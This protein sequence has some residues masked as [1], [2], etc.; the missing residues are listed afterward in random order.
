MALTPLVRQDVHA[1]AS[2]PPAAQKKAADQFSKVAQQA[3]RAGEAANT[4]GSDGQKTAVKHNQSK[5]QGRSERD[6]DQDGQHHQGKQTRLV[7]GMRVTTT[8]GHVTGRVTLGTREAKGSVNTAATANTAEPVRNTGQTL[9]AAGSMVLATPR[10]LETRNSRLGETGKASTDGTT[11]ATSPLNPETAIRGQQNSGGSSGGGGQQGQEG[12]T[13]DG[14][15][16]EGGGVVGN[17]NTGGIGGGGGSNIRPTATGA[18]PDEPD[19]DGTTRRQRIERWQ[20]VVQRFNLNGV[21]NDAIDA[22]LADVEFA[23]MGSYDFNAQSGMFRLWLKT[24]PSLLIFGQGQGSSFS[25]D[26]ISELI[27]SLL[28]SK[29]NLPDRESI[30]C[31]SASFIM[32]FPYKRAIDNPDK[33]TD[34]FRET[35]ALA[36][37]HNIVSSLLGEFSHLQWNQDFV[38]L[39]LDLLMSPEFDAVMTYFVS[40]SDDPLWKAGMAVMMLTENARVLSVERWQGI[41]AP[42]VLGGEQNDA[43]N[44]V[45]AD[46][47]ISHWQSYNYNTPSEPFRFFHKA[48][49]S[50]LIADHGQG[51]TFS[52]EEI[53]SQIDDLLMSKNNLPGRE[54]IICNSASFIMAFPYTTDPNN[55]D[56][57]TDDYREAF[58][59]AIR[60]DIRESIIDEL[61]ALRDNPEFAALNID[62]LASPAFEAVMNYFVSSSDG[63]RRKTAIAVVMVS[64]GVSADEAASQLELEVRAARVRRWAQ[65][66][67]SNSEF[68]LFNRALRLEDTLEVVL[69]GDD[70]SLLDAMGA[71]LD[72]FIRQGFDA[73][74]SFICLQRVLGSWN[75]DPLDPFL[76]ARPI[77]IN[78]MRATQAARESIIQFPRAILTRMANDGFSPETVADLFA[79]PFSDGP[80][81]PMAKKHAISMLQAAAGTFTLPKL[82]EL[83]PYLNESRLAPTLLIAIAQRFMGGDVQ[84]ADLELEVAEFIGAMSANERHAIAIEMTLCDLFET[85][86]ILNYSRNFIVDIETTETTVQRSLDLVGMGNWIGDRNCI[87]TL[88]L[89]TGTGNCFGFY[90]NAS[91]S[92]QFPGQANAQDDEVNLPRF[93][94]ERSVLP[95]GTAIN[96]VFTGSSGEPRN[97]VFRLPPTRR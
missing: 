56:K 77:A 47:E 34:D 31:N 13:T 65:V 61:S 64:E 93:H 45:L 24:L 74:R 35:F 18:G 80:F 9:P 3:T 55:P 87:V 88:D 5:V 26:E 69:T 72:A 62:L 44:G 16:N 73:D 78:N 11:G 97:V 49:A 38:A 92:V 1:A 51:S 90:S 36:T 75:R 79:G 81:F 28:T 84:L 48:L 53:S 54:Q 82:L 94:S 7:N 19:G 21:Q 37:R 70:V 15:N 39:E 14:N 12:D 40:S 25:I 96:M 20:G 22:L 63:L 91:F 50:F 86:E 41:E 29:S 17:E 33:V 66:T 83:V 67:P 6:Q 42:F 4:T 89:N 68:P 46:L 10:P 52:L 85:S 58:A 23:H 43:I 27:N 8:D 32:S 71:P 57:A 60:H 30:V 59:L 2:P 95:T 76:G